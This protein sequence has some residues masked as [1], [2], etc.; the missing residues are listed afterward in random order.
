MTEN[1]A[2]VLPAG[3]VEKAIGDVC[4]HKIAQGEPADTPV[5]YIDIGSLDRGRKVI[6]ET[7]KVTRQDAPT[8]ARQW[9]RTGDVLVSMTRPNL[10]AVASVP[11]S[12]DGAVASTGFDVLRATDEV[13]S[14]WLFA[15]VQSRDFVEDMC[16][17]LQGVVYP[18]IRPKDVRR[19]RLP[20][21]PLDEQDRIVASVESLLSRLNAATDTLERVRRNLSRYRASVLLAAVNGK[22][23]PSEAEL[24][25]AE[26][27]KYETASEL[28]TRVVVE[29]RVR[30][31]A[32]GTGGTYKEPV[33]PEVNAL[34]ALP[35]GWC[36]GTLD[37][38][39]TESLTNGRSVPTAMTGFPV[40][41]LTAL[42]DD[43]VALSEF[44]IGDWTAD[45]AAK[46][47]VKRGD[48]LVAR[49][50]GSI[51]RVGRGA[52]VPRVAVPVAYPDTLI[53]VRVSRSAMLPRF[54]AILWNSDAIRAH[55]ERAAKTTAGIFKVN[56]GDLA[57]IPLP[58]APV[59]EQ[60]RLLAEI[61]RR[62]T[63]ADTTGASVGRD[64]AR[65]MGL[66]H[67]VLRSA[68][69]GELV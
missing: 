30:W 40:L 7:S 43:G 21:P 20:I 45:D 14:G 12:M 28:L 26:G 33:A 35:E 22:L 32:S 52:L 25:R 17:E 10:N 27:R 36:W 39:L 8:R 55:I 16:R 2:E 60:H 63:V 13:K 23:V 31:E 69:R 58:I 3:W 24:A 1:A 9:V 4:E 53:R 51:R 6:G 44:K 64:L 37:Q 42:K 68:F 57:R 15:R 56:Q 5:P 61:E 34:P 11:P 19:H 46:F 41:R 62:L 67:G 54:L 48:F 38:L 47:L 65:M 50:N 49:G 66:R 59:P 29:R 18:A